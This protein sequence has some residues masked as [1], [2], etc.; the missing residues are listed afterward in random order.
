MSYDS[1]DPRAAL[2]ASAAARP[3]TPTVYTGAEL[4]LFY[5][6]PPQDDDANG[7]TWYIHGQN[8]IL[9]YTEAKPGATFARTNRDEYCIL[10]PDRDTPADV[11]AAGGKGH[12]DGHALIIMPPGEGSL[13]L[14]KGG[15]FV[16]LF[17]PLADDRAVKCANRA[18][19]LSAHLNIPPFKSWPEPKDGFRIRIYTLDVPDEPGRF[20]RI[21]RCTTMMVN[22]LAPQVGPRD[23]SK[24]SP[25]H[26]DDFEQCSLALE[27]G[28]MH[29]LRWPWTVDMRM[30]HDDLHLSVGSPSATI[31]P[32][33]VI[34]TT[35]GMGEGVNQLVDIFSPPRLDFSEKPGW[36]LNADE[37]PIPSA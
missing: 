2:A 20:G 25:H 21:W 36:V 15:R 30:W 7:R 13:S 3:A 35:R 29:H 23:V 34:H 8:M 4:D 17:S 31:I 5:D 12:T 24:L 28:S 14:P 18:S 6:Q 27:G 9:A 11:S 33:P 26:H 32:P 16:R 37:Y 22:F 10:V 19:F 1:T